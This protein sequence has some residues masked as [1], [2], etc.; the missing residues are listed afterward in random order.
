MLTTTQGHPIPYG[1]IPKRKKI[2]S[3]VR[4]PRLINL[5]DKIL[6]KI[7]FLLSVI[8]YLQRESY[9]VRTAYQKQS[10]HFYHLVYHIYIQQL[11]R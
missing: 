3:K 7:L 11:F 2:K 10:T 1:K 6:N 5:I 4:S 9:G 8:R